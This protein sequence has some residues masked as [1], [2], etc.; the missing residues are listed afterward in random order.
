MTDS[1]FG[2]K[3]ED[4]GQNIWKKAQSAVD[5]VSINNDISTKSRELSQIYAEL[6]AAYCKQCGE[7]AQKTFPQLYGEAQQ[8]AA[9]IDALQEKL[10]RKKGVKK[11]PG[12]GALAPLGTAY[13][14]QCGTRVPEPEP[15]PAPAPDAAACKA[16]GAPM[17]DGDSFCARCG[18]KKE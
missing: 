2:K 5:V 6:G 13:C 3:I 10:Q 16:C 7:D 15:E 12:C 9:E 14:S 11:C 18:A 8:L 17:D 1:D 4:F